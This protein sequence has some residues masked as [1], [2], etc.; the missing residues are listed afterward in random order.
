M[1]IPNW[2]REKV[3]S[4]HARNF[5]FLFKLCGAQSWRR[6]PMNQAAN[7]FNRKISNLLD[8]LY[9]LNNTR[10]IPL[11]TVKF[12][13]KTRLRAYWNWLESFVNF[14]RNFCWII[15][16]FDVRLTETF[17]PN[18][19]SPNAFSTKKNVLF[20]DIDIAFFGEKCIRWKKHS[21]KNVFG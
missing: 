16:K 5:V 10:K 3:D 6:R 7:W 9:V 8:N 2:I 12:R 15:R 20:N 1:L 14:N 17:L 13:I 19:F 21:V 4:A 11:K 18:N